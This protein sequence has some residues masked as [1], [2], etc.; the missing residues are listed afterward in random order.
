MTSLKGKRPSNEDKHDTIVNSDGS[1][2]TKA[3]INYFSVMDGH[4]SR[5]VS[6]YLHKN[7]S[8]CFMD[9]RVSYPL[10][11]SF[12]R[13]I[14]DY[15]QNELIREH[16]EHAANSGSTC[17]VVIQYKKQDGDFINVLNTGDS[18]AILCRGVMA[19]PLTL[20]HKPNYPLEKHRIESL[21][22]EIVFDGYD[23]R[24]SD[25]SVARAFGDTFASPYVTHLPDIYKYKLTKEDKFIVLGCD[26]LWDVL[27]NEDV[28]NYILTTCYDLSTG[29]RVNRHVNVARKLAELAIM[30]G[31]TDN[32]TVVVV[33]LK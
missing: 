23:Y 1:D 3:A 25:L 32:I 26:G 4:G 18:R 11:K 10:K 30:K 28:V 24:V 7:L 22:G 21:G 29:E 33:F 9:K 13:K 17:L 19:V 6:N 5:F 8:K 12:V 27:R 20:D 16:P 2:N 15:W 31:S 14:Y